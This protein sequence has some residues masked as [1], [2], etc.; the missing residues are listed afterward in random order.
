MSKKSKLDQY[1]TAPE[2]VAEAYNVVFKYWSGERLLEP[3]AGGGAFYSPAYS[4]YLMYDLEPKAEG[5]IR[6]DFLKVDPVEF[7]GCF[8]VG[9]PPFGFC[10]KLATEFINH[11]AK[12]CDKI[13]FILPN[14]FKKELFF[15]KNL[16]KNLHLVEVVP[17]PKNSFILD[18]NKY[19]VPCSIFYIEKRNYERK[20]LVWINY[21]V[22]WN[23]D[24]TAEQVF[25]RRVGGRAGKV[26]ENYTASSTYIVS[27]TTSKSVRCYLDKY[28][29]KIRDCADSTAGVRS[30][31][32]DEI[33]LIITRGECD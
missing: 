13:C 9:N 4:K 5:I 10:G 19:D 31:T 23:P 29:D 16:D 24:L 32:L 3:S 1:Y 25:V 14:T 8:A 30:I 11:C 20:P 21:L 12:G 15:D 6:A 2:A 7:K 17:L 28:A 27:S 22:S 33:N 26:V 18:G